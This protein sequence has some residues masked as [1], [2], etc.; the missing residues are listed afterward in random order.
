[1]SRSK[2]D[3]SS[4]IAKDGTYAL[5]ADDE[6]PLANLYNP[7]SRFQ[8]RSDADEQMILHFQFSEKVKLSG[9]SIQAPTGD[10]QPVKIRVSLIF[11]R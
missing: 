3:L 4:F 5:N 10:M 6:F 7:D 9:V 11:G 2:V 1:M 8:V